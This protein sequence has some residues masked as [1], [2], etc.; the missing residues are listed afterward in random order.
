[1]TSIAR[2]RRWRAVDRVAL[3][4]VDGPALVD[5]VPG[6]V[7][8]ATHD[9]IADRHRDRPATVRD[10]V[11]ALEALGTGHGDGA[12]A[13]VAEVLLHL[14]RQP[15]RLVLHGALDRQRVVDRGER[16]RKT[17]RPPPDPRPERSCPCSCSDPSRPHS[18][19]PPAISSNSCVMRPWRS[20]LYSSVRCPISRLRC[21]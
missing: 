12:H 15:H 9:A 19:W 5:R 16:A 4:G 2:Q 8:H 17:P 1:V 14:E 10:L 11:P 3:L 20:L 7:E 13:S 18:A 6:H 21:R